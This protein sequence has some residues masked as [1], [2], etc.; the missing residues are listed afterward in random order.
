MAQ[1]K[2]AAHSRYAAY[3]GPSRLRRIVLTME[4]L[5]IM[6]RDISTFEGLGRDRVAS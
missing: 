5:W 3:R 2:T 1:E 4:Y 6:V